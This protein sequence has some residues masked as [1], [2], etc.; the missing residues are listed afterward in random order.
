MAMATTLLRSSLTKVSCRC[1]AAHRHCG[2]LH[3]SSTVDVAQR[4]SLQN[5]HHFSSTA[6][7]TR[8]DALT[9]SDG[10]VGVPIDFDLASSIEGKESQ[11]RYMCVVLQLKNVCISYFDIII[12]YIFAIH[13]YIN[14]NTS[15]CY[16]TF[17]ERSSS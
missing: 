5:T 8:T 2:R 10:V 4:Y 16:C 1:I 17:R 7:D 14:T 12:S 3:A 15:D 9:S 13:M 11:V 6:I